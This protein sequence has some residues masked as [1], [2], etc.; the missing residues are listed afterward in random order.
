MNIADRIATLSSL[1]A[2]MNK[3]KQPFPTSR[4]KVGAI[5][6]KAFACSYD[7]GSSEVELQEWHVRTIAKKRGS[8][9]RRGRKLDSNYYDQRTYVY[10]IQKIKGVTWG[11]LS[12][13]NGDFGWLKS[14]SK[15]FRES[16]AVGEPLPKG[17]FTTKQAAFKFAIKEHEARIKRVRAYIKEEED[18]EEI[19]DLG[20]DLSEYEKELKLLKSRLTRV[21]NAEKKEKK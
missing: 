10:V 8:Q 6:F 14:I 7:D 18:P 20:V 21:K 1:R 5:L 11:K 13:K 19:A 4:I 9:T 17:M 12:R 16:F 15:N 2:E 3:G